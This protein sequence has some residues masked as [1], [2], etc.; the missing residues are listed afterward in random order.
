MKSNAAE[1]FVSMVVNETGLPAVIL[2]KYETREKEC[3]CSKEICSFKVRR[4]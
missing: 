2:E 1:I 3:G 4:S